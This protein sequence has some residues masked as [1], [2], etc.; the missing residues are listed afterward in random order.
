MYSEADTI[1][2][3]VPAGFR[4]WP[5]PPA[6]VCGHSCRLVAA[7]VAA[8]GS[9]AA[10]P[11]V[12]EVPALTIV[13]AGSKRPAAVRGWPLPLGAAGGR[14]R[15]TTEVGS[16]S[17]WRWRPPTS[18]C[19]DGRR[20]A[21]TAGSPPPP[22]RCNLD[23]KSGRKLQHRLSESIPRFRVVFTGSRLSAAAGRSDGRLSAAAAVSCRG[24]L[25]AAAAVGA[26]LAAGG[27]RCRRPAVASP[28]GRRRP[29]QRFPA[30]VLCRDR[31]SAA[32]A[33]AETGQ[34]LW[35]LALQLP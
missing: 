25:P 16:S 7:A 26:N 35:S 34:G 8:A 15:R 19:S 32:W 24:R 14:G 20:L 3:T 13:S 29:P 28:G 21:A 23:R 27:G 4:L 2:V 31:P 1:F 22:A 11:V 10:S 6:S 5:R 17:G 18:V 12:E 9:L 30:V 33:L